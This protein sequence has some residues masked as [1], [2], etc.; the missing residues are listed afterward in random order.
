MISSTA[1]AATS[2]VANPLETLGLVIIG[3]NE[4]ERLARCLE[5]VSG[6]PNRVYVTPGS[7]DG[8]VILARQNGAVVLELSMPPQFTAA[9]ARNAG[10]ARLL[11]ANPDLEFVQVVDG[12]CNCMRA[13]SLPR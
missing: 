8:S 5:S 11:A 6:I 2:E 10:I 1:H 3:R 7:T 4:G 13:G 9:R 12:D